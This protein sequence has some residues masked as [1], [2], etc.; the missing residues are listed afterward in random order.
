MDFA[1]ATLIYR[2]RYI[3]YRHYTEIHTHIHIHTYTHTYTNSPWFHLLG[4]ISAPHV[5]GSFHQSGTS[6]IYA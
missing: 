3:F 4:Y 5:L 6:Y 1:G 2:Y